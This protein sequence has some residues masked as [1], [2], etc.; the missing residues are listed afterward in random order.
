MTDC[1]FQ[2]ISPPDRLLIHLLRTDRYDDLMAV[3]RC[4][5]EDAGRGYL[6]DKGRVYWCHPFFRDPARAVPDD[7]FDA[8]DRLPVHTEL[9]EAAWQGDG[10][11]LR[12]AGHAY[13]EHVATVDPDTRLTWAR[14][15]EATRWI[16][17]SGSSSW[18]YARRESAG[19]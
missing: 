7:C 15:P 13:I 11:V 19:R 8:T 10:G 5:K 3:A 1:V 12:L 2:Q 14:W 16:R 17:V 9:A 4:A 18:T 6:V